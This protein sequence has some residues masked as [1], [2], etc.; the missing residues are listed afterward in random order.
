MLL[1]FR[2]GVGLSALQWAA[3]QGQLECV[4]E[5]VAAGAAL[6]GASGTSSDGVCVCVCVCVRPYLSSQLVL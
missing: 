4:R 6:G 1:N 5:L 2:R 3:F